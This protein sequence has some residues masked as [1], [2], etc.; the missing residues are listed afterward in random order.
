MKGQDEIDKEEQDAIDAYYEKLE[1]EKKQPEE[2]KD[3]DLLSEYKEEL[4]LIETLNQPFFKD[5]IWRLRE[6]GHW[7]QVGFMSEI[8][9]DE[10]F[11]I[12]DAV[13][14]F[15]ATAALK[16]AQ[17]NIDSLN[18]VQRY[19]G[20]DQAVHFTCDCTDEQLVAYEHLQEEQN[21][22]GENV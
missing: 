10:Y 14:R 15:D 20:F 2:E 18:R 4:Q 1:E 17:K 19:A 13:K 5:F 21:A 16:E 11:N 6:P 7:L 12:F 3:H 8:D 22:A 9:E